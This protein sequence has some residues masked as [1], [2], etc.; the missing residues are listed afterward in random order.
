MGHF[1]KISQT[2]ESKLLKFEKIYIKQKPGNFDQ[3]LGQ[4]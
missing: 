2:F 4:N 3:N 1:S